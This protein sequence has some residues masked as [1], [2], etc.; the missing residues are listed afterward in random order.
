MK[1]STLIIFILV[2]LNCLSFGQTKV[3]IEKKDGETGTFLRPAFS[4]ASDLGASI[5]EISSTATIRFFVNGYS[6]NILEIPYGSINYIE[7]TYLDKFKDIP[8]PIYYCNLVTKSGKN[9]SGGF[10]YGYCDFV[11]FDSDNIKNKFNL[12]T[13]KKLTFVFD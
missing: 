3:I 5:Y 1:K 9:Y 13:V 10:A 7:I 4:C 2:T 8:S 6:N 12:Q 11:G